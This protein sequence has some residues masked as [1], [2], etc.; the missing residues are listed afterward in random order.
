MKPVPHPHEKDS[1][2][3]RSAAQALANENLG[4]RRERAALKA[5][6]AE[7]EAA[8]AAAL[9]NERAAA[10]GASERARL[11]V[12]AAETDA[13]R[14]RSE[15]ETAEAEV[16][17]RR[18]EHGV[19][20]SQRDELK[21]QRDEWEHTHAALADELSALRAELSVLR[22]TLALREQQLYGKKTERRPSGEKSTKSKSKDKFAREPRKG[23]GPTDQPDLPTTEVKHT[24]AGDKL[25]CEHCGGTLAPMGTAAEASELIAIEARRTVLE[26]HL[27]QK[28]QC[29]CCRK[30]VT[31]APGPVKLI[32]GGRYALSFAIHVAFDKYLAHLPLER[33]AQI[34]RHEGLKVTTATLFDQV[35]ALATA[36]A[37]TFE[38]IWKV[39]QAE[40]VLCADETPW[41]VLSNGHTANERFYVWC[42]VGKR[43]VAYRL[44]DNRSADG[45]ATILGAFTGKLMVD[46]LTSYPAAAKGK[47]GEAPKFIVG[48]C[49]AHSRRKFIECEKHWPTESGHVIALYKRL[50]AVE[51][52]GQQ[53]GADLLTLRQEKSK[54][55][56]DELFAWAREQQARPEVL[57]SSGL[58]KALAYLLNHEA[59]LRVYLDHP[60]MP[61][62]NN[63][64][65]RA[66]KSPVLGRK[67]HYG[68]RSR[69][70]TE[71]AAILYTLI[72]SAKRV[73][74]SPMAYM[75]AVVEH[76]MRKAGAVLLPDEFKQQLDD[77]KAILAAARANPPPVNTA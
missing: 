48:N 29:P 11:A 72:E 69:R 13:R 58:A 64:A 17:R 56:L 10:Q 28:Y 50:Y 24:L 22:E 26:Q 7:L 5:R 46:G 51:R 31:V 55:L 43:Y 75:E 9:A 59:G 14:E 63:Q 53:P 57:D 25:A 33:Q 1:G 37:P 42:A 36:L 45:A 65:E 15:R 44:L 62:D 8:H 34:F 39:L 18:A 49:H 20:A 74:V 6:L 4:L 21:R 61:I 41:A 3:A 73:D 16:Q 35:D 2:L 66:M 47:P 23:H 38:A 32:L 27:R 70:G 68:S 67:N 30:G 40:A 54:P 52:E 19:L 76:S 71:V 60:D 12:E 77:A